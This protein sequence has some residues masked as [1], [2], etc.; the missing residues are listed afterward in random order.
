MNGAAIRDQLRAGGR[1]PGTGVTAGSQGIAA[2]LRIPAQGG[3]IDCEGAASSMDWDEN[4]DLRRGHIGSWR[5]TEDERIEVIGPVP[6][7]Q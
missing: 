1:G 5:F 2:T 6:F 3:E 4:G 7:V